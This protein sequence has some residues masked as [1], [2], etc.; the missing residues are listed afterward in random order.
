MRSKTHFI[1]VE[2]LIKTDQPYD[3]FVGW[4]SAQGEPVTVVPCDTHRSKIYFAPVPRGTP[5]ATI[6][7]LCQ[8]IASLPE[9]AR[10]QWDAAGFREFF[11]GYELGEEPLCYDDHLSPETLSAAAALRAGIGLALYACPD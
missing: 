3:A 10:Q 8:Q 1:S 6:R 11:V 9:P 4:F 5:D 2:I 7:Q